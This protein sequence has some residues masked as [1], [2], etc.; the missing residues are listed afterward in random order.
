MGGLGILGLKRTLVMFWPSAWSYS[1]D[2]FIRSALTSRWKDE[3]VDTLALLV[4]MLGTVT[5]LMC[6]LMMGLL[7]QLEVLVSSR[8]LAIVIFTALTF[9]W[10]NEWAHKRAKRDTMNVA[11]VSGYLSCAFFCGRIPERGR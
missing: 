3:Q 4:F 9:V 5:P 11:L 2:V 8:S 1:L 10:R 7:P 6:V